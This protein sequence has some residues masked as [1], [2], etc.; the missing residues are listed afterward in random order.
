MKRPRDR[1]IILSSLARWICLRCVHIN[2]RSV[3]ELHCACPSVFP[4]LSARLPRDGFYRNM[5]M[6]TCTKIC[7]EICF[8]IERRHQTLHVKTEGRVYL[9]Q[10]EIFCSSTTVQKQRV[11]VFP[12]R[13]CTVL[14]GWQL[15]VGQQQYTGNALLR[16]HDE[17]LRECAPLLRCGYT[18]FL[19]FVMKQRTSVGFCFGVDKTPTETLNSWNCWW[20]WSCISHACL[21]MV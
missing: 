12:W 21:L 4:H 7:R 5:I 18:A 14:Y 15:P 3:Y 8:K 2:W 9:Q 19:V 17:W 20:K 13:H 11:V 10:Y 16:F 1:R 6:G